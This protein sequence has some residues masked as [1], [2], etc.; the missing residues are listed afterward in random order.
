[1]NRFKHVIEELNDE[2][3]E[4]EDELELLGSQISDEFSEEQIPQLNEV[5]EEKIRRRDEICEVSEH[6]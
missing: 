4:I 3:A 1:M 6:N 5:L 2:I